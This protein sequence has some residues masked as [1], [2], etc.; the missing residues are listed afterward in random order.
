[1][2]SKRFRKHSRSDT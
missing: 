2:I 1:M